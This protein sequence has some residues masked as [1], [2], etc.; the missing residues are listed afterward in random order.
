MAKSL[1]VT[2]LGR[3]LRARANRLQFTP[4]L[5]SFAPMRGGTDVAGALEFLNRIL[6]RKAVVFLVSDFIDTDYEKDLALTRSRHDLIPVR[7]SDPREVTL[8]DVS[9]I[10][11]EDAET[12]ERVLVDTHRK[13]TRDAF[14]ARGRDD[15][16]SLDSLLRGIG[17]EALQIS[18]DRPYMRD[19][20]N[21]FRR[22][23]RRL[24]H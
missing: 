8:S 21:F 24:K 20:L 13:R 9:L 14:A 22:R 15:D 16:A 2:T 5:L 1:A 3:C 11:L 18:T 12:G 17:V 4:D 19:V 6:K 10:E 23:E 7:V